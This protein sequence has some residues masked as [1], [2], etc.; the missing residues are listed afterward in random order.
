M[1]IVIALYI[2]S[3]VCSF[4]L[5]AFGVVPLTQNKDGTYSL[6]A[7]IVTIVLVSA[8]PTSVFLL[9]LIALKLIAVN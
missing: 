1:L 4:G 2:Y 9:S 6:S 5:I 7:H 8:V 3:I